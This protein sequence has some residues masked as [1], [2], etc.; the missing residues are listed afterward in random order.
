MTTYGH[1]FYGKLLKKL[2]PIVKGSLEGN[3]Q[4]NIFGLQY[5]NN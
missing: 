1:L 2:V 4:K 5:I 3:M